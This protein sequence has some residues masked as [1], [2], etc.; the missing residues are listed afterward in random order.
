MLGFNVSTHNKCICVHYQEGCRNGAKAR[1][2]V[3][4]LFSDALTALLTDYAKA[5]AIVEFHDSVNGLY[6]CWAYVDTAS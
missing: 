2:V 6:N 5:K 1:R 3:N 4:N